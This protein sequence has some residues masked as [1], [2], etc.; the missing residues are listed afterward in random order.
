MTDPYSRDHLAGR[1]PITWELKVLEVPV[2]GRPQE[3]DVN[4][5]TVL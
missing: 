2:Q 1:A 5:Q 4:A 3:V